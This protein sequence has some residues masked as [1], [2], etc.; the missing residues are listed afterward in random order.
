MSLF[1]F[2][3]SASVGV[4]MIGAIYWINEF[5]E[6]FYKDWLLLYLGAGT[7]A[8]ALLLTWIAFNV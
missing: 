6:T 2:L 1:Q 5:I 7:L 8:L 4:L 3:I